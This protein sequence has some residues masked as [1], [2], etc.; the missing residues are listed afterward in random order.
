MKEKI[1]GI[2]GNNQKNPFR[3]DGTICNCL[4][5]AM[6]MGGDMCHIYFWRQMKAI[7]RQ[8]RN[9]YAKRVRKLYEGGGIKCKKKRYEKDGRKERQ[10][11]KYYNECN[12]GQH[13]V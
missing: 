4:P 12:K 10:Y 2:V 7:L 1:F 3:G 6:G 5:A 13:A 8:E 9:D 11:I